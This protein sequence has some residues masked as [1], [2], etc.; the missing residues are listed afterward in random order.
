MTSETADVGG[1]TGEEFFVIAGLFMR[2]VYDFNNEDLVRVAAP[3]SA[4]SG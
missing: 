4:I 1:P 2:R 3:D